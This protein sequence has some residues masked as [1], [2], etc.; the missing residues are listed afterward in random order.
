M[1]DVLKLDLSQ[2]LAT[3]L[4][5]ATKEA[6]DRA[7]NSIGAKGLLGGQLPKDQ[8]IQFLMMLWH[9]YESV[10]K[11]LSLRALWLNWSIAV[12]SNSN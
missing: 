11:P 2:P 1:A 10:F 12:H 5:E 7:N 9:V 4:R 6:H 8:Y 3:L